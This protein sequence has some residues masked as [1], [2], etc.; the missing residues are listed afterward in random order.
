MEQLESRMMLSETAAAQLSLVSTTGTPSRP[1]FNYD[2][3]LTNTGTTNLGTLWFAWVPGEDLLPS[4][5]VSARSPAG[6]G[7]A[8][9]ISST[10]AITGTHDSFDGSGIQWVAQSPGAAL[11]PGQS[12]SGFD[13]SSPDSPA[14]LGGP[15]PTHPNLPVTTAVV[16]AGAP[17]SD[18][19]FQ[20][21]AAIAPPASLAAS[22][23][24]L[25]ASAA[26]ISSGDSVTFTAT[27]AA[28][29]PGG[30]AP[31]GTVSF[32]ADGHV[33]GTA[34]VQAGGA[35]VFLTSSL[36]VGLDSITA[37]Y[38]GDSA[39]SGSTSAPVAVAVAGTTV[40]TTTLVPTVV[41]STL[42]ASVVGGA[43]VHGTISVRVVNQSASAVKGPVTLE[44]FATTDGQIDASATLFAHL[45]RRLNLNAGKA[46]V[47]SLPVKSLPAT[48]P[49]GTYTLIAR[50]AD[51]S[52]NINTSV[53][54][55]SIQV[56]APFI[57]LSE[58][59]AKLTLAATATAGS[60]TRAV[61]ALRIGNA[62][63]I[64]SAG[65]TTI[66]LFVSPDGQPD[67]SATLIA[68]ITRSL[69]IRPGKAIVVSVP[70]RQIPS[71]APGNYSIVA[72]V[73]GPDQRASSIASATLLTIIGA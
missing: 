49:D 14:A 67:G 13:F 31:T 46:T 41:K 37:Q 68:K 66:A 20:L 1:V 32:L 40:P 39:Y 7:N 61:A 71:I 5:P 45:V 23:T 11:A 16:Y 26:S 8:N 30:A 19:G 53:A 65:L 25:A 73:I 29:T 17:L 54:G 33:L 44:L 2:I 35:S 69:H 48:L 10:P 21:T 59:F 28:V 18:P 56:A 60:K 4:V 47:V 3:T 12:L 50:A 24:S 6:W 15:S 36:P 55:P 42:P 34:P 27:V 51:P 38:S 62:G 64:P 58:S 63:N 43:P 70:L 9:G 52:S 72:N 22:S 57:S